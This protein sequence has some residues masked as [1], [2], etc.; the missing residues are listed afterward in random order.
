MPF[1]KFNNFFYW[2]WVSATWLDL[3]NEYLI[4]LTVC[5]RH[6]SKVLFV[7]VV[8]VFEASR[9][10]N[11]NSFHSHTNRRPNKDKKNVPLVFWTLAAGQL[12]PNRNPALGDI[13]IPSCEAT[14]ER[15]VSQTAGCIMKGHIPSPPGASGNGISVGCQVAWDKHARFQSQCMV[16]IYFL[17]HSFGLWLPTSVSLPTNVH[18]VFIVSC[19]LGH[20][21]RLPSAT[22]NKVL[23]P[24]TYSIYSFSL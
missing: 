9:F 3:G 23:F 17:F 24:M 12:A 15:P 1:Q 4:A 18:H 5:T 11:I 8:V 22:L 20:P 7:V 13:N 21:W 10:T 19:W 16:D 14:F 2:W 6:C